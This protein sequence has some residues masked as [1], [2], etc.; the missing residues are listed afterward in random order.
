ML[1]GLPAAGVPGP[2]A[3]VASRVRVEEKLLLAA[4]DRRRIAYEVVDTRRFAVQLDGPSP[5]YSGAL[6]RE[7]SHH[8]AYYAARLFEHAGV[9]VVNSAR[10]IGI[11]G[12]KLLTTLALRAAGVPT[13]R[14]M[15]AL[16]PDAALA[17][18]TAF[19]YPSVVKPLIGS[20]GR[21]AARLTDGE[22]AQ[23]L[24]EHRA[25]LPGAQHQITYVQ[26]YI[27]KPG[28]DIRGLVAGE[29]VLGAVYRSSPHWRTN[30][31][32]EASTVSLC[33]VGE[34][35]A[36]LLAA[37]AAAMGPGC[38]GVDVL[39]DRDGALYV[40]EVNHTPELHGAVDVL[41]EGVID[42]SLD[43]ALSLLRGTV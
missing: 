29:E 12:D 10:A 11:C 37:A 13:P 4:L 2:L 5:A 40:S 41:G 33:P 34:D 6:A 14:T 1:H 39:E 38:Y 21:L 25:A 18:L 24:L 8:R 20:W 3:I 22:T 19:G 30:T 31:A 16:T 27:D 7:V 26:Q 35:L 17:E 23:A 43:Y 36:K 28:R 32:R 9:P 42:R 15:V